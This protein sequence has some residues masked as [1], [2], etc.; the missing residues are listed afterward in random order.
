MFV[1][2]DLGTSG[3]KVL[4]IDETQ[5]VRASAQAPLDVSRPATGWSEQDPDDWISAASNAL[6]ALRCVACDFHTCLCYK[7]FSYS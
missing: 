5:T 1:G 4:L 6:H 3:V 7:V 2:I